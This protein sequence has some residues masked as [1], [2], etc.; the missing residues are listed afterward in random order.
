MSSL[1]PAPVTVVECFDD[2]I[3]APLFPAEEQRVAGAVAKRRQEYATARRCARAALA[4]YGFPSGPL[5]AGERGQPLWPAGMVGSITHCPGYRAAAV[6]RA[7]EVAGI[8]IDAEPHLPL[9]DGVLRLVALAPETA[10]LT[11]LAHDHPSVCWDRV[12]FS[13]KESIYK[14]WYPL[15]RRWLGCHDAD[16]VFAPATGT[17]SATI[18]AD[19]P[20]GLT[21][22]TGRFATSDTLVVTAATV[23]SRR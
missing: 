17:F 14:A 13:A 6:G 8:G 20:A 19:A 23:P 2:S 16:V 4:A 11:A 12:L 9:R 1:L 18:R 10:R 15:T 7:T 21:T 22:F 5:L 3:P